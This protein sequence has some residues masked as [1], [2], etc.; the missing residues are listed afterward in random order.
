MTPPLHAAADGCMVPPTIKVPPRWSK[1][2][3]RGPRDI[4]STDSRQRIA[5][6]GTEATK[7]LQGLPSLGPPNDRR[8]DDRI[9]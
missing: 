4:G 2:R 8:N 5:M 7:T 9:V 1:S 6:N 3:G